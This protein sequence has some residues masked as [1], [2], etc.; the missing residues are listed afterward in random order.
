MKHFVFISVML[1][2]VAFCGDLSAVK[3]KLA[4]VDEIVFIK[5]DT[6]QSN[7]YYTDHINGCKY[8]GGNISV[9]SLKD[10]SVRDIVPSMKHGIFGRYDLSF[11]AKK[12]V[13]DWKEKLGVGFRIYEVNIDGT[14]LRQLTFPPA[15][16]E[17]RIK[18]YHLGLG[19]WA[20]RYGRVA[21]MYCHHTDDMHPCYLPDG[22]IC[23]ISS[24]CEFGIL[25]DAPDI[26]TTTVLYRMDADGKNMEKLSNSSVSEASPSI[27]NDGRIL[28][29]RWEYV[30]KG[31]VSVKCL[32]AMRP[33]GTGSAEVY[34]NDIALPPTMLHGKAIQGHNNLFV[35]MGTP[36]C[37]QSGVGTVILVDTNKD[38]RTRE[39]MTYITPDIDIRAEGGFHHMVDGKWRGSPNGP[40][41]A[42]A[43]P[44][45]ENLFLVSH[46]PDKHWKDPKAWGLYLLDE[47]GKTTPV[48]DDP[49]TSCWNP[50][51]LKSRPVPPVPMSVIDE[52]TAKKNLATVIVSD[53]YHGMEGIERGEVKYIRVNEQ[54]PRPWGAR[55]F[56][57]GDVYDQQHA[58]I[59]KDTHL[60]LRVQHGIV[61]VYDD[62]SAHFV[63]PAD[64]NIF[65]QALDENY[66]ELQ[67][68]RTY[69]NY[70]PGETR[71]CIG[72]HEKPKDAPLGRNR[73]VEA[74]KHTPSKPGPQPG[75]KTGKRTLDFAR[76]VQPI[77]DRHCVK[78]HSGEKPKAGLNLSGEMTTLFSRSY[79]SL[80]PERRGG[81]GRRSFDLV[82]P[83]IG[84]NHPKVGNAHYLPAKSL[85]SHASIL[86]SM[87]NPGKV[88]IEDKELRQIAERL[89]V[90]HKKI[91][92]SKEEMVRLTTWV[93]CNGQ[94]YGSYYGRKNLKYKDHPNFRPDSTVQQ[95]QGLLPP[96]P[97][98]QR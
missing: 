71:T 4:G 16:E 61:P 36:H 32:W 88:K 72:C 83:T 79:E 35:M 51:P 45:S 8:F 67:R 19:F 80:I 25:C 39:P 31:A 76:D 96:L 22:G 82:G 13:F 91:K 41:F 94:Y 49:D 21:E 42:D 57:G 73:I 20:E 78:C 81:Q 12:I 23:F 85:G 24:R 14:G 65:F 46:N 18:K 17:A 47:N 28:Y 55:R 54:I 95:A 75:E 6:Y 86:V 93:D 62:G 70:P 66:M 48:Y 50:V 89:A 58:C 11:D 33:D 38:I 87:L 52:K 97:E 68:E 37:P 60:G 29:T 69:V 63:V 15:D 43:Y 98:D 5:R 34:G 1:S 30:D 26:F 3:A 59:T 44:L 10:G 74:L 27:M 7:H 84:E 40:L 9:L 64:R 2:S 53:I 56:W 90:K 77:L 92:L